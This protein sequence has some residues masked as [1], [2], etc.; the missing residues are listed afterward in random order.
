ME[1]C[2]CSNLRRNNRRAAVP[3]H[4]VDVPAST[5]AGAGDGPVPQVDTSE[6]DE[7]IQ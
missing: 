4:P 1:L 6:F 5:V 2:R 7:I 3:G